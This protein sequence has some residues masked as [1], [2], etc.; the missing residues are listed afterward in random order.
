MKLILL[1]LC[2]FRILHILKRDR[3][4]FHNTQFTAVN[5]LQVFP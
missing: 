4:N 3:L 2:N 1:F 5:A